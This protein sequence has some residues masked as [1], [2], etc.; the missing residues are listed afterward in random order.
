M[1]Y[2]TALD[3]PPNSHYEQCGTA[4]PA[5]CANPGSPSTCNL[6]CTEGCVCDPG[7][8]LYDNKCVPSSQCGCWQDDKH[9]PVGSEF[10][11]DDTCSTKCSCPSAGGSLVCNSASCPPGK[12]CG[13]KDGVPGCYDLTFGNC[14]IYGD[15]H[16]DTFDKETHHFMGIC[17]YTLSKVCSNYTNLPYFNIEA[18]NEHRGN[19]TVSWVQKVMVEVYDHK[20]T[21]VKNERSRILVSSRENIFSCSCVFKFFFNDFQYNNLQYHFLSGGWHLDKSSSHLGQWISDC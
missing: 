10:W 11:T 17:T 13:I 15:P 19:P 9:Y 5:T 21:I 1:L 14:V 16:Y 3:C 12:Y 8:V 18:K 2:F 7:Y 20:I 4:C 6:P